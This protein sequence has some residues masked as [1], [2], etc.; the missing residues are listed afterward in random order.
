[1]KQVLGKAEALYQARDYAAAAPMMAFLAACGS[2]TGC[3]Y[4]A[5]L[6]EAGRA[7]AQ[8]EPFAAELYTRAAEA[9]IAQADVNLAWMHLEGR[10]VHKS[11][12]TALT[13]L[14]RAARRR[15]Y[16]AADALS[17]LHARGDHGVP[18]DRVIAYAWSAVAAKLDSPDA[19]R[20]STILAREL[21]TYDQTVAAAYMWLLLTAK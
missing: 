1:M 17:L 20:I 7:V 4:L 18:V 3:F 12:E 16:G 21:S 2:P 5:R 8:C 19:A 13:L 6:Y 11:H 10:G 9:G 14:G 15:H